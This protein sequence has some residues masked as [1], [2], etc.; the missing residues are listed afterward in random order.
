MQRRLPVCGLCGDRLSNQTTKEVGVIPNLVFT[1]GEIM[2][3]QKLKKQNRLVVIIL[4]LLL[5]A[6]LAIHQYFNY[7]L[8]PVDLANQQRVTVTIPRGATDDE[9]ARILKEKQLVRSAYVFSYYLQT[10]KTKGVKAGK[11]KL[12]RTQS[13]PQIATELQSSRAAKR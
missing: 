7:A 11:F 6:G 1:K 4:L 8:R 13:V 3:E 12:A 10:H 5:V 2:N 9:V